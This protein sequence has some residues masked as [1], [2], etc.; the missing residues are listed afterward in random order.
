MSCHFYD[1]LYFFKRNFKEDRENQRNARNNAETWKRQN[2]ER[3]R[4]RNEETPKQKNGETTKRR[5]VSPPTPYLPRLPVHPPRPRV[6]SVSKLSGKLFCRN[7]F[8]GD[9]EN[10]GAELWRISC[11]NDEIETRRVKQGP[12]RG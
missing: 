4:Q 6:C 9:W 12:S 8:R 1:H 3:W 7:N 2:K 11:N 5:D 10:E